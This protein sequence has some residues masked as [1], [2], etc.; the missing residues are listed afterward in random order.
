[1]AKR[2]D[3]EINE[4]IDDLGNVVKKYYVREGRKRTEVQWDD[5]T[6]DEKEKLS[7][8]W[9]NILTNFSK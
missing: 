6:E 3:I 5:F 8:W 7:N 2:R 1:M 4:K 9:E